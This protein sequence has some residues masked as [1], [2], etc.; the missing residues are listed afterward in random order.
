MLFSSGP[1]T[2]N[3]GYETVRSAPLLARLDRAPLQRRQAHLAQVA[4]GGEAVDQETVADLARDF[5][6]ELADGRQED[7]GLP[8]GFGPGLKKGVIK[9]CV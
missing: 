8:C 5:G 7:L 1:V 2:T 9:V 3:P 4:L 6:H